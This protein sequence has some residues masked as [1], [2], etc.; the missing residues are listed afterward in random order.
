MR[1]TELDDTLLKALAVAIVDR[2]RATVKALAEAVGVSK[3]TLHRLCGTREAL[4][5]QLM[6]H[7]SVV[8]KRLIAA[9]NLEHAAPPEALRALIDGHLAERELL[10]FLIFQ[11]KPDTL[12]WTDPA[13]PWNP[14]IAALDGY[15][16][17]GQQAGFFRIDI[18]AAVL[19][20]LFASLLI[21]MIDA[22]RNGRA[23]P[24]ASARVLESMFLRGAAG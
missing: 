5:E 20:D 18:S 16:L 6:A 11:Y 12:A 17:R 4:I 14:Y 19:S 23:A 21:G 15:F 10:L 24:A 8:M 13:S 3:A 7:T 2:P 22:E 9:A 1:R